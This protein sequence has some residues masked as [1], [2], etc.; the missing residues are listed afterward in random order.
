[1]TMKKTNQIIAFL[2]IVVFDFVAFVVS[3]YLAHQTRIL[4]NVFDIVQYKKPFSYYYEYFFVFFIVFFLFYLEGIYTKR[5]DIW[6]DIKKIFNSL[7]IIVVVVLSIVSITKSSLL[8]SRLVIFLFWFYSLFIFPLFHVL[9]KKVLY[10]LKLWQKDVIICGTS[11]QTLEFCKSLESQFYLGYNVF[12]FFDR[13]YSLKQFNGKKVIRSILELGTESKKHDID[14]IFIIASS[15]TDIDLTSL[16]T[17]FK[18]VIVI[19]NLEGLSIFNTKVNFYFSQKLL[20][21][22]T[23]NNLDSILNQVL[24]RLFDL[25]LVVI[26]LPFF[27]VALIFIS[28]AIKL[29]SKGPIFFKHERVGKNG[30][31]IKIYKFRSMYVDAQERLK[32][33]LENNEAL[34]Q[35]W[36]QYFKLKNDPRITKVGNFLRK[37]SL[38]ELPQII[39]IIKNEMSFVGPRPVVQEE[40]EKYYKEYAKFYYIVNPGLTGLWQVS[41]RN[42]TTYDFRVKMDSWYVTNWSLWLDIIILVKTFGVVIKKEGVY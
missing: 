27:L 2:T 1:M 35:E 12:A 5:Y 33:L 29:T 19:P 32:V 37:T 14:T 4:L 38:D 39:N 42:D 36:N 17:I 11:S 6:E 22:Q 24:K 23:K 18:N 20:F 34:R 25:I 41:G 28:I 15:K 30:K 9:S 7:A 40:V 8:F 3:L 10:K 31:I 13:K 16:Q 26:V 21:I